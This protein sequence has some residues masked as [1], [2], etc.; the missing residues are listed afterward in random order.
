MDRYGLLEQRLINEFQHHF[1]CSSTPY[2]E[3][4]EQ[5]GIDESIVLDKLKALKDIGVVSRIG[6][7]F[8]PGRIGCS[9]LAALAVPVAQFDTVAN[10][11]SNLPETNHNYER[12]DKFNLW[13]VI[14]APDQRHLSETINR[15]RDF[16]PFPLLTLPLLEQ[17]HIDLGFDL[18]DTGNQIRRS[19]GVCS[20]G[21]AQPSLEMSDAQL[22][23]VHKLQ[24]GIPLT[25]EPY[26]DL[27]PDDPTKVTFALNQI[28]EWKKNGVIKRFGVIVRH[29]EL[30][31]R[32]NAMVVWDVPDDAIKEMGNLVAK[33]PTVTLCYRRPR[34]MPDWPYNL[35]CMIHGKDRSVVERTI[36]DI[37]KESG[38]EAYPMKTLFSI[39]RFKQQGARYVH[40]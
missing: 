39:R 7:V 34:Q 33:I 11:I 15:I 23:L 38:L 22:E 12:E 20:E 30:G 37:G 4:A 3:I 21:T 9:T 25:S 24:S 40:A 29:H 8:S 35:F 19:H 36:A 28:S 2:K 18:R 14:T 32:E 26:D 6:P 13:F 17:F 5:L 1:P 16:C 27:W 31:Y 10:W